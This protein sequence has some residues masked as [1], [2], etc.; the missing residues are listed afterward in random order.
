MLLLRKTYPINQSVGQSHPFADS[1]ITPR[2]ERVQ[3]S[4]VIE[5]SFPEDNR[6]I[7]YQ[8]EDRLKKGG[9]TIVQVSAEEL[10]GPCT[11]GLLRR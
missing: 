1:S 5:I 8:T 3:P 4:N 10:C 7:G 11:A 6:T 2:R 9:E